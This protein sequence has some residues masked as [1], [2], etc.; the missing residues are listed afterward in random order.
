MRAHDRDQAMIDL[1]RERGPALTRYARIFAPDAAAAQDLVQDAL[2]KVFVR[3]R[4][5]FEPTALEGYVRRTIATLSVDRHRQR[6]SRE[7]RHHL[8][9]VP[10]AQHD[11]AGA[12]DSRVDLVDALHA[13]SPQERVVVVLRFYED[14]TVP[15]IANEMGLAG[16]T[17]KRYLSNA[18][19]KLEQELGPLDPPA[20]GPVAVL[21]H[22][23]RLGGR[24]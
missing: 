18:L 23:A 7:S 2:V 22:D 1:V 12:V 21:G 5:G 9:A 20:D 3:T 6:R 17:V 10:E 19:T 13:L 4:R 16:G 8:V 15:Q 11:H 24:S 14:L